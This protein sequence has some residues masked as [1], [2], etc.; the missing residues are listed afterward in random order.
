[1]AKAKTAKSAKIGW[2]RTLIPE[3]VHD[4]DEIAQKRTA[5]IRM[6]KKAYGLL[7]DPVLPCRFFPHGLS[8]TELLSHVPDSGRA[9]TPDPRKE[10]GKRAWERQVRDWRHFLDALQR[11]THFQ[12]QTCTSDS[13][14]DSQTTKQ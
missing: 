14:S 6:I 10:Q 9:P 11:Q 4:L 2:K 8:N 7:P 5:A 12:C 1:M 3:E 13:L